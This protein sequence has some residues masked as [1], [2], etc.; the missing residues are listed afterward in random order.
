VTEGIPA[1][2][3]A[4]SAAAP[5]LASGRVGA[6][7][8]GADRVAANGDTANKVGTR[9]LAIVARAAGVPFFVAA[10]TTSID[11]ALPSGADIEIEMRGACE[12]T[13]AASGSGERVVAEGIGVW[14]PAFDVADATL[15]TSA[16]RVH[17]CAPRAPSSPLR[18]C[19]RMRRPR[20]QH[21]ALLHEAAPHQPTR[22]L[23]HSTSSP[24]CMDL[25][26][27]PPH[28]ARLHAW[29]ARRCAG[30]IT[31]KGMVPKVGD[32]FNVRA[33]FQ[34]HGLPLPPTQPGAVTADAGG[35][36]RALDCESVKGYVAAR[37]ELAAH[38]GPVATSG[39]WHCAEIG[40]GNINFVYVVKGPSGAIVIKQGLPYIRCV[41]ESWPLSQV[42]RLSTHFGRSWPLSHAKS[43]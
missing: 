43:G 38:V 31:E 4:D 34:Q 41:G 1:T 27:H 15:I 17:A 42:R 12:L 7:V 14:N 13:H 37:A 11:P 32:R 22:P 26:H 20:T 2:L 24:A 19:A 29:T 3:V 36:F 30:I 28:A 9:M 6:V 5:L 40:D 39:D 21:S 23:A 10:P 16:P 8:V 25:L 18:L 33:F 35:A